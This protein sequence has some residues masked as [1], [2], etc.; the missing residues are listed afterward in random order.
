MTQ[1]LS[2][3]NIILISL[4]GMRHDK[5]HLSENIRKLIENS[6]YFSNM[7][8]VSPYTLASHH[9]I[10][11]GMQACQ[12]GVDAYYHMFRFKK[13]EIT[14]LTELLQEQNYYTCCDI[15]NKTLLPE[16]GFD[17]FNIYDENDIDF[18]Q[19]HEDIISR[20]SKNEK[21]FLFLQ[22]NE[23][24]KHLVQDV[25]KKYDPKNNDD[26]YYSNQEQN[27]KRYD[28]YMPDCDKYVGKILEVLKKLQIDKK[29]ILILFSDHG[30]SLGERKGERFYGVYL[31]DYT[32]DVFCIINIPGVSPQEVK[33][34]CRTIDIFPTV[35]NFANINLQNKSIEIPAKDLWDIVEKKDT[36][37]RELFAETG[38]L[39]GFWP[40]PKKHNVFCVRKNQ[41]KIIFNM[42][43][44]TFEFYDLEKDPSENNNI[45]DENNIEMLDYKNILF[46]YLK[47]FNI[48]T[49]PGI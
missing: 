45:F 34:Q 26:D 28:S 10:F 21:F 36:S 7:F 48:D 31:Y 41:K 19:R 23:Q 20:L 40:S 49:S 43:P 8:T 12:N 9:A 14:T 37:E 3:F 2:D 22:Y 16:K 47:K 39:Y 15:A 5:I 13:D 1:S 6:T 32:L 11:S 25:M 38:G 29:T 42:T 18:Q 17:E 30:T 4:D 46:D 27:E 24:H 33:Q 44:N 35:T